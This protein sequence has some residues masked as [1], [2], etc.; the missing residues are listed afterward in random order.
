MIEIYHLF[1]TFG[2]RYQFDSLLV[3]QV[4]SFAY[5]L[6]RLRV[7]VVLIVIYANGNWRS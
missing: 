4:T 1:A 6:K 3:N 2:N 5:L 7:I